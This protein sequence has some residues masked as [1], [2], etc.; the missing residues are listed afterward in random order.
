MYTQGIVAT[1]A[2]GAFAASYGITSMFIAPPPIE[3]H[4]LNYQD[5]DIIQDR[6]VRAE[7]EKFPANWHAAIYSAE[8]REPISECVGEG[9]WN[10]STGRRQ[11]PIPVHEWVG[12]EECTVEFVHS[13]GVDVYP[14]ASWHWGDESTPV[15]IG[16]VFRP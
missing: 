5:G 9:F 2:A 4:S 3:V 14:V 16:E 6:T 15:F 8:T 13:L 1:V 10:Y 7:G 12:R 11:Y